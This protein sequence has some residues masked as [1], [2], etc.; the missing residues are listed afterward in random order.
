M[1]PPSRVAPQQRRQCQRQRRWLHRLSTTVALLAVLAGCTPR[2]A[3]GS[4]GDNDA[5]FKTCWSGCQQTGCAQ[6]PGAEE[7]AKHCEVAC[8]GKNSFTP[9]PALQ[10]ARWDCR[11]DCAYHCMWARE[12]Q[13]QQQHAARQ[14]QSSAGGGTAAGKPPPVIKYF[15]KWPF[16]R[17][18]GMQE[19]A[20]VFFSLLNLAAH[21]H[22]LHRLL[23]MHTS[24]TAAAPS[25]GSS[26]S[27][28]RANG[29]NAGAAAGTTAGGYPY[30][31]AWVLYACASMNAWIWSSVFHN[32]DTPVT[33]RLDYLVG[34][35]VLVAVSLLTTLVRVGGLATAPRAGA[36]AAVVALGLLCHY[37]Y[38][39][40]VK[41]DYSYNMALCISLG[42]AQGLTWLVWV[43]RVRHPGRRHMYLFL[44][45]VHVA[46]LLEVLD[47]PPLGRL[48]DAHAL[49]HAATVPLTYVW[50][51]FVGADAAWLVTQPHAAA[52]AA[53]GGKRKQ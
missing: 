6:L 23:A 30:L 4:E 45:A 14:Q 36:A 29:G 35:N 17:V 20:S 18:L 42:V 15:G 50:Y 28:L 21:A 16:I 22:C 46:M 7:G 27:P 39:L 26:G 19:L 34:A 43:T 40:Y 10:L 48:V 33:E 47:F 38:M 12:R 24:L 44:A 53:G 5:A 1:Q 31:W 25:G 52:L 8:P 2:A 51:A 49:W 41:F 13:K 11:A 32:R 3:Q 37:H 9:P